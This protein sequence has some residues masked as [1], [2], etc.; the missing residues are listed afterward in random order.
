MKHS[1]KRYNTFL[2][3]FT[4][5][6]DYILGPG[7]EIIISIWGETNSYISQK[8]NRRRDFLLKI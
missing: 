2:A 1:P 5:T 3:K 4:N 7:D 6:K 8:I